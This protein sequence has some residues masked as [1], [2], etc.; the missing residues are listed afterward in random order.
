MQ[1]NPCTDELLNFFN[2]IADNAQAGQV[3]RVGA[4]AIR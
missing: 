4:P 2:S 1:F 3:R